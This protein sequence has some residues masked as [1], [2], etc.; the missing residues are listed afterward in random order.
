MEKG[1]RW[2][3]MSSKEQAV[4]HRV[5]AD[6][7]RRLLEKQ[8]DELLGKAQQPEPERVAAVQEQK[9]ATVDPVV[10]V[11]TPSCVLS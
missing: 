7:N 3:S 9:P 5:C 1:A 6:H 11:D 8:K 2:R 10:V 4:F